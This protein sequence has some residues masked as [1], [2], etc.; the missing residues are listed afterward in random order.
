MLLWT[1]IVLFF[2][3]KTKNQPNN[4]KI[5]YNDTYTS[6][7]IPYATYN[8]KDIYI[9]DISKELTSISKNDIYI[10]DNRCGEDPNISIYNSYQF[11]NIEE[12][13]TIINLLIDYEN[14]Y[15]TNWNRSFKS[16]KTEWLI[17]NICYFFN[18]QKA[19]TE[20]VDFNNADEETYLNYLKILKE[21][22][23]TN[24]DELNNIKTKSLTNN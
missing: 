24:Q 4:Q 16:M 18:I 9:I 22:I 14:K 20:Q 1:Y 5:I 11:K 12:I 13:T 23:D 7:N 17:H 21:I 19:R 3:P 8:S 6:E 15:P 2:T 10:I